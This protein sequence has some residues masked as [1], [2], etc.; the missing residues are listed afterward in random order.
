[1]NETWLDGI[2]A[3]A[4][5]HE[6]DLD[7]YDLVRKDRNRQGGGIVGVYNCRKFGDNHG[8]DDQT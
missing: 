6:V 7:R 2:Q 8:R 3:K 4:S 1:V 5:N